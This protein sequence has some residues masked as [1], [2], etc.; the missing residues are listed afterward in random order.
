MAELNHS[1]KRIEMNFK[2]KIDH[3]AF[4]SIILMQKKKKKNHNFVERLKKVTVHLMKNRSL[5]YS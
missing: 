4:V 5:I 2:L 3:I 1:D